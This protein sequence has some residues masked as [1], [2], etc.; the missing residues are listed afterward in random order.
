MNRSK[1]AQESNEPQMHENTAVQ[2]LNNQEEQRKSN[3]DQSGVADEMPEK[4]DDNNEK[5]WCNLRKEESSFVRACRQRMIPYP[6]IVKEIKGYF[7]P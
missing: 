7:N 2:R 6:K 3:G 1:K 5:Q 4:I